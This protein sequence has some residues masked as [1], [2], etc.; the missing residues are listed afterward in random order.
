MLMEMQNEY[1]KTT[2]FAYVKKSSRET[3][4]G[5][6]ASSVW[7]TQLRVYGESWRSETA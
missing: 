6:V 4:K 7:P 3:G 2:A 1:E 5:P